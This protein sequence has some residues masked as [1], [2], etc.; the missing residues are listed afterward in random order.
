MKVLLREDVE[1][2]G[3]AGEVHKV[4][5][6]YGRNYL[7]PRGLAVMA[8]PSMMKQ[9]T[10]WRK[11]ADARREQIRAEFEALSARINGT[12]L[13]FQAR[14]G[15]TG[16]LYGSIT[17]QQI[18]DKMNEVL[19]TDIDRRKVGEHTLR[20]LGEHKVVVRLSGDFQPEVTVIIAS[21]E[22][23]ETSETA[24]EAEA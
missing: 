19:G 22:A 6:G 10:V 20:D 15:E 5:P 14:A 21:D 11:K 23:L 9:A 18:T 24:E 16:R 2:L 4:A 12:V 17:T 8:T 7:L 3:Y 1:S 13:T